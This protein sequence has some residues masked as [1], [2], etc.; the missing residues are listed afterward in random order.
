MSGPAAPTPGRTSRGGL[1]ATV[2]GSAGRLGW[3]LADQAVSSLTNF[4]VTLAVARTLTPVEF[5][6]FSLAY[7]TYAFALNA[8]RG[9]AT[10]PLMVRFNHAEG[11]VRR[12][13]VAG[14]TATALT[15]GLVLAAVVGV[16]GVLLPGPAGGSFLALAVVLPGLLLQDSWRYVFFSGSTGGRALV[17]DLVWAAALVPGV[18]V[19][20]ATGARSAAWFVLAWGAAAA[21]AAVV[22][23]VQAGVL[24][25]PGAVRGWLRTQRDLGLRYLA[26]GT[27]SAGA[28]QLRSSAVGVVLGLSAVGY[29]QA[30][31]TLMGPVTLVMVGLNLVVVPEIA[32]VIRRAPRR[33]PLACLLFGLLLASATLAWG[34]VLLLALPRGLGETVLGDIWAGTYPVLPLAVLASVGGSLQ[35]GAGAGLRAL[36]AARRS[37]R[38]MLVGMT[39]YVALT[40]GGA[41]AFGLTGTM[42]GAAAAAWIGAALWWREL[43]AAARE[44]ALDETAAGA[45]APAAP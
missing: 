30:A 37:L 28:T 45:S 5:G 34:A 38:A 4:A 35:S 15:I 23:V 11:D 33:V 17:N 8:S 20:L 39:V 40:V 22:G 41:V 42:A 2:R 21:L 44:H 25:A 10:D 32:R 43:R 16:V 13:A 24:P 3:G 19:L 14:S 36:G 1:V 31:A 26:E 27:A 9:L 7:V 12:A 6:A 18:A 29:V